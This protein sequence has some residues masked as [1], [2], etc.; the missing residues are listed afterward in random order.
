MLTYYAAQLGIAL[1]VVNSYDSHETNHEVI[2]HQDIV[3]GVKTVYYHLRS[4]RNTEFVSDGSKTNET[5]IKNAC[6]T[7]DKKTI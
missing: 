5:K 1:S 3:K 7:I 6:E 4:V 2:Q